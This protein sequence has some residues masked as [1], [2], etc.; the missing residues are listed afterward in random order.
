MTA[1]PSEK[2]GS[3]EETYTAYSFKPEGKVVVWSIDKSKLPGINKTYTW[4]IV[5]LKDETG[6]DY[7]AAK[8]RTNPSTHRIP[9]R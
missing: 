1:T 8:L 2:P 3:T 6:K 4:G 9:R 5:T 7:Y